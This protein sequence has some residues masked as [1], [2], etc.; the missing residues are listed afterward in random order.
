MCLACNRLQ[1][2]RQ[3]HHPRMTDMGVSLSS[4]LTIPLGDGRVHRVVYCLAKHLKAASAG[5]V[6]LYMAV[7]SDDI[8][9]YKMLRAA[10]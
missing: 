7:A 6:Q 3:P 1:A 4:I 9:S 2:D 10:W 8:T 5:I